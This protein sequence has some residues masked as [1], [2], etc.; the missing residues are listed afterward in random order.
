[1]YGVHEEHL[2]LRLASSVTSC[3]L[4]LLSLQPFAPIMLNTAAATS[5]LR[6]TVQLDKVKVRYARLTRRAGLPSAH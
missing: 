5:T 2:V 4:F 3:A 6:N 1:V